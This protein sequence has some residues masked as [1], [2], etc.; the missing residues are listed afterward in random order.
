VALNCTGTWTGSE[1]TTTI[2]AWPYRDCFRTDPVAGGRTRLSAA[3][4]G[5]VAWEQGTGWNGQNALR[6]RPPDGSLG[7]YQGYAGLGEHTFHSVRTKRLNIRYLVRYNSNWSRYAQGTKWEVAI[8]YDY[9]NPNAP[10][11]REGCDR[12]ITVSYTDPLN[13]TRN[14][15][16]MQQGVCTKAWETPNLNGWNYGPG[17]RENEW[18]SVENEFDLETGWYRTYITTQDGLFNQ[19]LHSQVNIGVGAYGAP[20]EAV[21]NPNWWGS[22]DCSA[23]CFWDWA[24]EGTVPRPVDTYIWFSHFMMSTSRI[25]P[26]AGFLR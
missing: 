6:V 9:S 14:R 17:V 10:L 18:I 16:L 26:P 7:N 5:A 13:K 22:I 3:S 8:K 21:P 4:G 25:G 12:G 23:G 15:F 1:E 11:R 24:S 20:A 2:T 19:S